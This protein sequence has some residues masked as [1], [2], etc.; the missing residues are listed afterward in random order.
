MRRGQ[1][2]YGWIGDLVQFHEFTH[3]FAQSSLMFFQIPTS[4]LAGFG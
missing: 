1:E 3:D 2:M 4:C